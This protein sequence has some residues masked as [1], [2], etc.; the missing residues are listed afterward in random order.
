M[1][2]HKQGKGYQ[3]GNHGKIYSGP[4]AEA[5]AAKQGRAAY[6]N[7]YKG[8]GDKTKSTGEARKKLSDK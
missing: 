6:A 1:P 5:K 4:G 2:V 3:W 8:S 7:G